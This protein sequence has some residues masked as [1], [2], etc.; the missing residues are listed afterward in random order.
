MVEGPEDSLGTRELP[1][2]LSACCSP[3]VLTSKALSTSGI[4]VHMC[5]RVCACMCV[6]ACVV[7]GVEAG[8]RPASGVIL[9]SGL[10]LVL[11]HSLIGLGWSLL[12]LPPQH[13]D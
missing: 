10:T 2:D 11:R 12:P 1:S 3:A 7:A 9:Q 13:C 6:Y 8:L 5:A 4:S